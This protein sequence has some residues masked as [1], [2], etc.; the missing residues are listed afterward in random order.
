VSCIVKLF[1]N[2]LGTLANT[3][4]LSPAQMAAIGITFTGAVTTSSIGGLNISEKSLNITT[5]GSSLICT[6]VPQPA[7]TVLNTTTGTSGTIS[8]VYVRGNGGGGGGYSYATLPIADLPATVA[9]SVGG[10]GA[11]AGN[12]AASVFGPVTSPSFT[13]SVTAS[14][15]T[16]ASNP[17]NGGNLGIGFGGAAP[18]NIVSGGGGLGYV[19]VTSPTVVVS[20]YGGGGGGN[21]LVAGGASLFAGKGGDGAPATGGVTTNQEG[22]YPG[23]GGGGGLSPVTIT[24]ARGAAGRVRIIVY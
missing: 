9:V 20:G 1:M 15:G 4:T 22:E 21:G 5:T 23:G 13:G 16:T 7:G 17:T 19:L 3:N 8:G 24:G 12:G 10:G 14:N 11:A 18:S 6:V 2:D